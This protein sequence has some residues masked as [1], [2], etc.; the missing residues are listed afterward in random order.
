MIHLAFL[1]NFCTFSYLHSFKPFC[2]IYQK[3][4]KLE[5]N[6]CNVLRSNNL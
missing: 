4:V 3:L 5:I 6:I 1:T 2:E